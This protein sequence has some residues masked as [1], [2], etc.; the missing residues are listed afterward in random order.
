MKL[1]S[2]LLHFFIVYNN[3]KHFPHLV[4][5]TPS[6]Y[7]TFIENIITVKRCRLQIHPIFLNPLAT[8]PSTSLTT[9][10]PITTL[11]PAHPLEPIKAQN[12][13]KGPAPA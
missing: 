4:L 7:P 6:K 9:L 8:N 3:S 5:S 1:I 11:D 2:L 10:T 13:P 12:S